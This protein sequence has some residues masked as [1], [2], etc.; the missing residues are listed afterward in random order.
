MNMV[1]SLNFLSLVIL[2]TGIGVLLKDRSLMKLSSQE[3]IPL[4]LSA[5]LYAFVA[6]SNILEH[7]GLTNVFDP[8]EDICEVLFILM[9]LFFINSW[10]GQRAMEKLAGE[11]EKYRQLIESANDA[12]FVVQ[13]GKIV[14][15]NSRTV[16]LLGLPHNQILSRSVHEFVSPSDREKLDELYDQMFNTHSQSPFRKKINITTKDSHEL[17]IEVS[18][19]YFQWKERPATLNFGRDISEQIKLEKKLFHSQKM[20]AMGTLASGIAHD[21]N[22]M[23]SA[24]I[25]YSELAMH[26]NGSDKNISSDIEQVLSASHR[27]KDLIKQILTYSRDGKA[28]NTPTNIQQE[29]LDTLKLLRASIPPKIIIQQKIEKNCG[30][31]LL[32]PT[33]IHQVLMNLCINSYHAMRENGG[34]LAIGLKPILIHE[35]GFPDKQHSMNPGPYI[36]LIVEDTGSGMDKHTL[37]RIFDPY[38]TTKAKGD[39]TGLGLSVVHGI[40]TKQGGHISA[41]SEVGRGT[42]FQVFLPRVE[43]EAEVEESVTTLLVTSGSE[44]ALVVD[45]DEVLAMMVKEMLASLGYLPT[46][47]CHSDEAFSAFERDPASFDFLITDMT[48]PGMNGIEL[49]EKIRRIRPDIPT[50]LCSG[51]NELI[52]NGE[53]L[54]LGIDKFLPKPIIQSDLAQAVGQILKKV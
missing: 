25:G 43:D 34:T 51:L 52:D 53:V 27:A 37:E 47:F 28:E 6:L 29:V 13:K 26:K 49:V 1:V 11:Q 32:S 40:I 33:H 3:F 50:I 48:M 42:K 39:G 2:A 36:E 38:F 12:I 7:S 46:A 14:F 4:F 19:V 9:S 16:E 54:K 5:C 17:T 31:V 15:C 35:A 30:K 41:Y 8:V 45:D 18:S 44:R 21:F 23:L 24:I 20:E 10:R 22:N